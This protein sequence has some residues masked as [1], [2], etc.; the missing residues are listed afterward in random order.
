MIELF[1]VDRLNASAAVFDREK[2]WWMNAPYISA[3]AYEELA[4]HLAPFLAQVGLPALPA[5]TAAD[6]ARLRQAVE[7]H[8][9]RAHTLAELA[10][11]VLPYFQD[12]LA[13][14]RA[15]CGKFLQDAALPGLL[16]TLRDRWAAAPALTKEAAEAALRAL[17]DER[18]VKA[19]ALI[20]PTR[21]ALSA[22]AGGPPLFD[23][24]EVMGREQSLLR[25]DRFIAFLEA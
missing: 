21:M 2:L 4:P 25:L 5:D 14:D 6:S 16:S 3:S 19:G 13:Y 18:R 23:L 22:A 7:L 8:R 15:A 12:E 10:R 20:H 11:A 9:T 24:V 17:A 1:S